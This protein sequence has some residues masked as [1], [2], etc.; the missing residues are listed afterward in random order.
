MFAIVQ[1]IE[2]NK[3]NVLAVPTSW[4]KKNQLMWPKIAN[5]KMRESGAEFRGSV[6][7][8]PVMVLKK[9]RNFE[10][11]EKAADELAKK[12]VSDVEGKQ[13]ILKAKIKPK[14]VSSKNY[15]AMFEEMGMPAKVTEHREALSQKVDAPSKVVARG[16]SENKRKGTTDSLTGRTSPLI[17]MQPTRLVQSPPTHNTMTVDLPNQH[18]AS[19]HVPHSPITQ[20]AVP[21]IVMPVMPSPVTVPAVLSSART[22]AQAM[23][24]TQPSQTLLQ[25]SSSY[26][27]VKQEMPPP[28]PTGTLS[29]FQMLETQP[30]EQPES[31]ILESLPPE[32]VESQLNP[33]YCTENGVIYVTNSGSDH[34]N[35]DNHLLTD[36]N[37]NVTYADLKKDLQKFIQS[38]VD[39]AV[40]KSFQSHFTRM[41][42]LIEMEGR[43][44]TA[45]EPTEHP[46]EQHVRI[47]G[48]VDLHNWNAK[49]A[50][51]EL[52]NQYLQYFTRIIPPNSYA[53]NGNNAC[54]TIVDCLF[55]REFWDRFTWT[56]ISRG[57]KSKRGFREFGNVLGLLLKLVQ[58]GDPTYTTQKLEE[59]CRTRLFR[60][61]R[62]RC[63]NK[64]LRKSACRPTRK[65]KAPTGLQDDNEGPEDALRENDD[66]VNTSDIVEECNS[67]GDVDPDTT[68]DH[69]A[70]I[71][72]D[73]GDEEIMDTTG[74]VTD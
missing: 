34:L 47:S 39:A 64:Q 6:K 70:D 27:M 29:R 1:F 42:T 5:D 3:F 41:T 12:D 50:D 19:Q 66:P 23:L 58:I 51:S 57:Q 7:H 67:Q 46:V 37:G 13:K 10:A 48:E 69:D 14:V 45:S 36:G 44:K 52:C 28:K 32:M 63:S 38:S 16:K 8:I 56:G 72:P 31:V 15:D 43:P 62:S 33:I 22:H 61:S 30:S 59:F 25:P 35:L 60:Y 11:A 17:P 4:I 40:E 65:R 71:E 68:F 55:T 2:N 21:Q 20:Q 18:V 54:Y 26:Q 53:N 24:R 74:D 73:D 9:L 49:L